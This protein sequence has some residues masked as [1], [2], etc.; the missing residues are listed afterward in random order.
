MDKYFSQKY[1]FPEVFLHGLIY[2]K[3][4]W[5]KTKEGGIAYVT[6]SEKRQYDLG[7]PPP[8]DVESKWE[9]LSKSKGNVIDPLELIEEYGTDAVRM[10]LCASANQTP[11]IDLDR[12]R[13]EEFKNFANKLWNGARFIFL[14]LKG[15]TSEEVSQGLDETLF[16]F[17]D[18]WILSLVNDVNVKVN[19]ALKNYSFDQSAL[20]A[21]DF[22]WKDF[23]AYYLEI[24]KP[25]LFGNI[26]SEKDKK[27]KQKIL[28]IVLCN[29]IRLMHPMAPFITEELFQLLKK[30]FSN[31]T[32]E[33]NV[34]PY[35]KK[36]IQALLAP[37]CMVAPYPDL[38]R[39]KDIHPEIEKTFSLMESLIYGIRNIRG[40]MKI[41][42]NIATS[43]YIECG[44]DSEEGKI[45]AQN[46]SMIS[47][48]VKT[49]RIEVLRKAP[50]IG[51]SASLMVQGLKVI[52]PLPEELREKELVRLA[53]E[54]EKLIEQIDRLKIQL[55]NPQF[56]EK[57][58]PELVKRQEEILLD[59]AGQLK[60]IESK[61]SN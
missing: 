41:P 28:L 19:E 57:A 16:K 54:R 29:A 56:L 8:K 33:E 7:E 4:Y 13:F 15:L 2:G 61:L 25:T 59:L 60:E 49:D 47:A 36:S 18:L 35:T 39:E 46:S 42:P 23:C 37:A 31:L 32:L 38:I 30:R 17:E 50:P 22:Y 51:F 27:N 9:K 53:K 12:R 24:A 52:I 26:G 10:S 44:E 58:K 6:G 5:R 34:D 48:L 43:V 3:S 21:Y 45:A 1:P 55:S 14:N 20:L 40:E 11:Q